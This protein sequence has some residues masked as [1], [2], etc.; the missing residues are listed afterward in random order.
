MNKLFL[1]PLLLTTAVN[2]DVDSNKD[3]PAY[4]HVDLL[5]LT[6]CC[7]E[8]VSCCVDFSESN[9]LEDFKNKVKAIDNMR[10]QSMQQIRNNTQT[11]KQRLTESQRV[12][13]ERIKQRNLEIQQHYDNRFKEIGNFNYNN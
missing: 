11:I 3:F 2:A 4:T 7:E 10:D 8:N 1:M 12:H 9:S 13:N 6:A 5:Q